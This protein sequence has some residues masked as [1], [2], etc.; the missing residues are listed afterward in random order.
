MVSTI[1]LCLIN[2]SEVH[3]DNLGISYLSENMKV[4]L[5]IDISLYD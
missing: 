2:V 4:C 5:G 3:N 1:V